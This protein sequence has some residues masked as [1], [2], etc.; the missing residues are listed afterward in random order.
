MTGNNS[1]GAR[2]IQYGTMRDNVHG[3]RCDPGRRQQP[4]FRRNKNGCR[5]SRRHPHEFR[6]LSKKLVDLGAARGRR[7]PRQVPALDA[8]GRGLQ[9]RRPGAGPFEPAGCRRRQSRRICWS[10]PK[11]PSP[12]HRH[13]SEAASPAKAQG[14][15][16]LP[17][18]DLLQGDGVDAAYRQAGPDARSNWSTAL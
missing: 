12:F 1:C 15:G 6:Q 4:P 17:L 14:V 18:P 3:I 16:H 5:C 11:A 7:N 10:G 2:S 9:H 13:R 8:A